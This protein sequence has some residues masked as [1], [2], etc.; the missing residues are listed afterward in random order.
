VAFIG[1]LMRAMLSPI[2][3]MAMAI[4][5]ATSLP[6]AAGPPNVLV[7]LTDD[8]GFGDLSSSGN[9]HLKTPQLDRLRSEGVDFRRF[10]AA[11][12]GAATRAKLLSGRHEFRCGVSHEL[13]GRNL[14]R[15][16]VPLLPEVFKSAGY[17]TAIIGKWGL[18]EAFPC[19]PED[20]GFE[21]IWV[22]GGGG[23]GQTPDRWGNTNV[24]PWVRTREGWVAR[25]GYCT[26]VWVTEAKRYL[27]ARA[28]DQ[29]PFFLHL[30]L[31]APH[32]PYEAPVGTA[33]RFL[34]AGLQEPAASFHA[35]IE[36]L[37]VRVGEL[38]AELDRLKLAEQ[39]IVVFLGSNGSA[40][41][42]W[43][44]GLR[45]INGSPDEGGV[46]VPACIRWPGKITAG[47][48]ITHLVSAEDMSETVVRACGLEPPIGW[49]GDGV[50]LSA[51][52]LG[53]AEFNTERLIY[54]H[55]GGWSGDDR[56]DRHRSV[57]FAVRNDRWLLTGLELFDIAADSGQQSNVF[58]A[59]QDVATRL[60]AAY[61]TWWNSIQPTVRE[62]VRYMIGDSRQKVVRLTANDWWPSREVTGAVGAERLETQAAIRRT[63]AA[64][65][66]GGSV[67]ETA[68]HWKLRVAQ[69]GHYRVTLTLLPNEAGEAERK[70]LGQLK[71]GMVHLRTDKREL[72]MQVLKGAT[73]VTL[74]LDLSAG[75]LDL[76]AWFSG[77]LP[78]GRILGALFAEIE[79]EGDRKRPELEIDFRTVPKK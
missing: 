56:P 58:E 52:L 74:R 51:A 67:P 3:L 46:R 12:T 23:L 37:D 36:D 7:I 4:F 33:A 65:A 8:Q 79:R 11:P 61:G 78:A 29:K 21:E 41:G 31:N 39:T 16:D 55:V 43:N 17:R 18:G 70:Q 13:A 62:P 22:F 72:Q 30:A 69:D 57:G 47:R 1:E 76:E 15:P 35:M 40:L 59:H 64:L 19:R 71:A 44:A 14:I 68:G 20:R 28:A 66:S 38:L 54:T 77:Q 26:Q 25:T 48:Q 42:T 9:P 50:D 6:S 5:V 34:K 10:I 32:A 45:G 75:A 24:D 2:R 60:L 63:L 49:G 73:A 27:A 53:K